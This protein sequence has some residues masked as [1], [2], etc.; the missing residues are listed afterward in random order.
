MSHDPA[1]SVSL[2]Q[3]WGVT[4]NQSMAE[5]VRLPQPGVLNE[6]SAAD[7]RNYLWVHPVTMASR[8]DFACSRNRHDSVRIRLQHVFLHKT[9][10]KDE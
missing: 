1:G 8:W 2:G 6:S 7:W 5:D 10:D 3:P 4:D 9:L